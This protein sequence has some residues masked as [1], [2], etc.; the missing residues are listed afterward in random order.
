[1]KRLK[2]RETFVARRGNTQERRTGSIILSGDW[3]TRHGFKVGESVYVYDVDGGLLVSPYPPEPAEAT[4]LEQ[5]KIEFGRLG[6]PTT[7]N[8][9]R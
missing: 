9:G 6:I 3:L 5:V 7:R 2:V 1:M 8:R 4:P